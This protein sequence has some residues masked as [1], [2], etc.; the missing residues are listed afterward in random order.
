MQSEKSS[1]HLRVGA[2]TKC[3]TERVK[4]TPVWQILISLEYRSAKAV[5]TP[6]LTIHTAL[7][8]PEEQNLIAL[9]FPESSLNIFLYVF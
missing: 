7:P 6:P 5:N 8:L 4:Y 3:F 2:E 1:S 9:T